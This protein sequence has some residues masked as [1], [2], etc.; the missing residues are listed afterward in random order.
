MLKAS[1]NDRCDT[2]QAEL[3]LTASLLVLTASYSFTRR[4]LVVFNHKGLLM[5]GDVEVGGGGL[6]T[7]PEG[8]ALSMGPVHA[9][10]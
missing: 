1:P 8:H 2:V 9:H 6:G 5:D 7:P 10:T 3:W 4:A